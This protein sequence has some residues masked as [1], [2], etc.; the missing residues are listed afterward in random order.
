MTRCFFHPNEDALYECTSCGKPICGQCMRFDEEDKVICPACT[1]ESA[2][3]IADDDT[4]EYLELRHRKADDTKKK[5]TKLEAALEV[6]NGWYIVLILLLLGTLIYMN[7]YIDRAGLPAVN[8]L[9]RFKQM[10]D[11][12]L[13]MTYIA[14]KIF[15]YANENDGQFPKELKGLVPKYLPEPPTILDTGEPYVYSLIEGEE[16]FILNLPRADRYNY[17]RL[18][19]MGDGV[20]KLE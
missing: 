5:K 7:H 6:I 8:E 3:E 17:R 1:L 18:F 14:S 19:I 12:S 16:Q 15:L 10:G 4:R 11:P 9:K 13:Q 2:V 20:L